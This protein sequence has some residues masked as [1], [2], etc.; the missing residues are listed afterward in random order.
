MPTYQTNM[1]NPNTNAT[2]TPVDGN[3]PP[4]PGGDNKKPSAPKKPT[5]GIEDIMPLLQQLKQEVKFEIKKE[6][7][8]AITAQA[9]SLMSV[10]P[11]TATACNAIAT[12]I[13][14]SLNSN[15]PIGQNP[16]FN[17]QKPID[18]SATSDAPAGNGQPT[19]PSK[20][21]SPNPAKPDQQKE[22][23]DLDELLFDTTIDYL[24]SKEY[25]EMNKDND[26]EKVAED[27]SNT[28]SVITIGLEKIAE[29]SQIDFSDPNTWEMVVEMVHDGSLYRKGKSILEENY[30]S[31]ED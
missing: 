30:Y 14:S 18:D 8:T 6:Q 7:S 23:A 26:Q 31:E 4:M 28:V 24:K 21:A 20:P 29:E 13:N 27:I 15:I 11:A 3:M 19:K 22:A 25:F 17:A 1:P 12:A 10:D 2:D 5:L 16:E 9:N